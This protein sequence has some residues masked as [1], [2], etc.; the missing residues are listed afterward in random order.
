MGIINKSLLSNEDLFLSSFKLK[1]DFLPNSLN[2]LDEDIVYTIRLIDEAYVNDTISFNE[3][4]S[5]I[6]KLLE[7][8]K[9][10]TN[11]TNPI[12]S[13][14]FYDLLLD[15]KLNNEKLNQMF[16]DKSINYHMYSDG[17]NYLS[18]KNDNESSFT[19]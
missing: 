14:Q 19:R 8:L 4:Y 10:N 6:T 7:G 13:D 16:M 5:L 1:Y 3:A 2:E 17:L 12:S 15:D 9:F 11:N 18:K